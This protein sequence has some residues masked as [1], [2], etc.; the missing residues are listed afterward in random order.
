MIKFSLLRFL[1]AAAVKNVKPPFAP[2]VG[3]NFYTADSHGMGDFYGA[4]AD[5][6]E[7]NTYAED[8]FFLADGNNGRAA[9]KEGNA[10]A[11][12]ES[13]ALS[14][15]TFSPSPALMSFYRKHESAKTRSKKR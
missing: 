12:G 2:Y 6:G 9:K 8:K 1:P 14:E 15:K 5:T 10:L 4:R 13:E 11:V 3:K 7:D